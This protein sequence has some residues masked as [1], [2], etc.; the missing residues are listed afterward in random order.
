MPA[1]TKNIPVENCI[2]KAKNESNETVVSNRIQIL[3]ST[4]HK[5][6]SGELISQAAANKKQISYS[7]SDNKYNIFKLKVFNDSN[8]DHI[9]KLKTNR[10]EK[11]VYVVTDLK[12]INSQSLSSATVIK[13]WYTT[14]YL[15][16]P[17]LYSWDGPIER[18]E[19]NGNTH[20]FIMKSGGSADFSLSLTTDFK[21]HAV[22]NPSYKNSEIGFVAS[23]STSA[24]ILEITHIS[25]NDFTDD[26][27]DSKNIFDLFKI[28]DSINNNLPK[29]TS[30]S[31]RYNS[32]EL[33]F[34][35]SKVVQGKK[36]YLEH[37]QKRL[38][39]NNIVGGNGEPTRAD[40]MRNLKSSYPFQSL[41]SPN[42]TA[43]VSTSNL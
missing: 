11:S 18:L 14:N 8:E 2:I 38:I 7:S 17:A 3:N 15:T 26:I 22:Q 5:A 21:C 39:Y 43:C 16:L 19:K 36:L 42:K 33:F 31:S 12:L 24:E 30:L 25:R 23:L 4:S 41:T 40:V 28:E 34:R 1:R 37:E 32:F 6:L 9:F 27:I 29:G 10:S 20:D 35:N 13:K